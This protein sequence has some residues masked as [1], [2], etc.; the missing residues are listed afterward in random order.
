MR[1]D[2]EAT[3]KGSS[4]SP[5]WTD[6]LAQQRAAD[7]T[8]DGVVALLVTHKVHVLAPATRCQRLGVVRRLGI[9]AAGGAADVVLQTENAGWTSGHTR[10]WGCREI[11][12]EP[13]DATAQ[14]LTQDDEEETDD[15]N[16]HHNLSRLHL[17]VCVE[18]KSKGH[19]SPRG[20]PSPCPLSVGCVTN[21][22][23]LGLIAS[24][25]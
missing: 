16:V 2:R 15:D 18:K 7:A 17:L 24:K 25:A 21:F 9:E 10:A 14:H 4:A 13:A 6:S 12:T 23:P 22:V 3:D 5:T 20:N 19:P 8:V 1:R 11:S